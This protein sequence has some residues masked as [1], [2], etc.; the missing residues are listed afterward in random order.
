MK[1]QQLKNQQNSQNIIEHIQI[2]RELQ[3]TQS[4]ADSFFNP[5]NHIDS[6]AIVEKLKADIQNM[7]R[8]IKY[9]VCNEIKMEI[10][11]ELQDVQ[12][13]IRKDVVHGVAQIM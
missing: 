4:D 3:K 9:T 2:S 7:G 5:P 12:N 11:N 13:H 8:D 1:D 6:D 10:Q